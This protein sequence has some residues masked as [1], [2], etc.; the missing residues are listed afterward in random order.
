MAKVARPKREMK[1]HQH[2]HQ[3]GPNSSHKQTIAVSPGTKN[4]RKNEH[5]F[6]KMKLKYQ[7]RNKRNRN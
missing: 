1:K 2:I 5:K 7:C 3:N 6:R 4:K